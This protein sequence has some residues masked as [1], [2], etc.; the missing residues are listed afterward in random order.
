MYF[1]P[2]RIDE[3]TETPDLSSAREPLRLNMSRLRAINSYGIRNMIKMVRE[4]GSRDL[5]FMECPPVFVDSVNVV[6]SLLGTPPKPARVTSFA[7]PYYCPANDK[8]YDIMV[9]ASEIDIA[10]SQPMIPEPAC[11]E[12]DGELE[13]DCSLEE[14]LLFLVD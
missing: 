1:A 3:L 2:E 14:Y 7:I 10:D 4:W 12:C 5:E 13:P 9:Q 6:R 8:T 11:D